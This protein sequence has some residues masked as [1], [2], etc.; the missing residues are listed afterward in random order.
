MAIDRRT[1]V[2]ALGALFAAGPA[3]VFGDPAVQRLLSCRS[4]DRK[5][6][7]ATLFDSTGQIL[8]DAPLPGRG[9]G[10]TL[11][12]DR[13]HAVV[14]A[15][16]PGDF[17]VVLDLQACAVVQTLRS[18]ADRHFYGHGVFSHDGRLLFTTENDFDHGGGRIGIYDATAGFV[19]LGEF[20]SHGIGPHE[21]RLLGD[22]RTLVVANGGIRTHPDM[23]RAKLNLDTM[24]S[25]L[26]Y[27]DS[28][29]GRLLDELAG[30]DPW[31]RLS[32]RHIDVAADDR[33][34]LVMQYEGAKDR[35]PPLVGLY[36][37]GD[38]AQWLQAPEAVQAR[39]RNY[40]GSVAFTADGSGFAVS[41]PRG[42]L[43]T[44]WTAQGG[45]VGSFEQRDV[46]G[47]AAGTDGLW[48]SDGTGGLGLRDL[49]TE[50]TNRR[51][52]GSRWDN[53]LTAA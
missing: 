12:P 52:S 24:R 1:F 47:I 26:S 21:L 6:H 46:C 27:I 32:I 9:H 40:C 39:M 31:Q 42:G 48:F 25:T 53:H 34:A 28:A 45:F 23:P 17:L 3:C 33:V 19:R 4:D 22:G 15:R 36:T 41:S 37:R 35:R 43:V 49:L 30:P 50:A 18:P 5:R 20:D 16:R 7:F 51:F 29:D 8:L 44:R 13:R 14:F 38:D 10:I 2:T 11:S